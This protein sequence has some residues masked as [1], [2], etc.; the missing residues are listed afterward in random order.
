MPFNPFFYIRK[1]AKA[2]HFSFWS[3][4]AIKSDKEKYFLVV[5]GTHIIF[6]RFFREINTFPAARKQRKVKNEKFF[7]L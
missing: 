4:D 1:A 2:V 7:F 6:R 5:S 3:H